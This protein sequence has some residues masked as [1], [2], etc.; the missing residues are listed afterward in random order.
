MP[1]LKVQTAYINAIKDIKVVE[2]YR[3]E[4]LLLPPQFQ[5][6]VA[7]I[8]M[9][10]LFGILEKNIYEISCR[11]ACGA[12]YNNGVAAVPNVVARSLAD[13]ENMFK[14]YCRPQPLKRLYFTNVS[15]INNAIKKVIPSNEPIRINLGKYINQFEEMR[16]VRNQIAHRN[17]DTYSHYRNVIVGRYGSALKLKTSTFLTSRTRERIPILDQYIQIVKILLNDI[18]KGY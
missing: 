18:S 2:N 6:F 10:R 17:R 11:V 16:N 5:G 7:E 13:A 12:L 9:L 8:L 3:K 4:S 1:T 15:N 14:N